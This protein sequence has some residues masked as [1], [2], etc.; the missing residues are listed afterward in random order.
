MTKEQFVGVLKAAGIT[1]EQMKKLHA[2]F[3][4]RLPQEHQSFLEYL[5]IG[6]AEIA[7]I[8]AASK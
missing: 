8:R 1:E 6:A 4:R 3:E 7:A 5:N 2:E